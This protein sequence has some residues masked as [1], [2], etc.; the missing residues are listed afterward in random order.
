LLAL[1]LRDAGTVMGMLLRWLAMVIFAFLEMS[2]AWGVRLSVSFRYI[3][4]RALSLRKK[5]D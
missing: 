1:R 4:K 5:V 3:F 2:N